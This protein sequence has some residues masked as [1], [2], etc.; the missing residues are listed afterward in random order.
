MR[1]T[2]ACVV[3]LV[4][5]LC[6]LVSASAFAPLFA[7][8]APGRRPGLGAQHGAVSPVCIAP[9]CGCICHGSALPGISGSP[10]L[11]MPGVNTP[12]QRGASLCRLSESRGHSHGDEPCDGSHES[13]GKGKEEE[14]TFSKEGTH[15]HSHDSPAAIVE[16]S[17]ELNSQGHSHGD[18]PCNGSHESHGKGMEGVQ[19][20][21]HAEVHS[22]SQESP[23]VRLEEA[24]MELNSQGHSH[25]GMA[26]D[27]SHESHGK[28]DA[29]LDTREEAPAHSHDSPAAP[30]DDTEPM[31]LIVVMDECQDEEQIMALHDTDK[32]RTVAGE[33]TTAHAHSHGSVPS[34]AT[35][36]SV[37]ASPSMVMAEGLG[38][39]PQLSSSI[40]V[41]RMGTAFLESGGA[42]SAA[43]CFCLLV[44]TSHLR[45]LHPEPE[46]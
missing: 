26:C 45:A 10:L 41:A 16:V 2:M 30:V 38:G 12:Q 14:D 7:P 15:S 13:H 34:M 28:D 4:L 43:L 1:D 37:G 19:G 9:S 18:E 35:S 20:N 17:M 40:I 36:T 44:T 29:L 25:G 8:V 5:S 33:E 21:M 22:H 11:R 24:P 46:P 3:A 42:A 27:G 32:T 23:A 39:A 31:E 6:Y